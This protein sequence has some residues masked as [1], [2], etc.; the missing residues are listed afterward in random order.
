MS[1]TH[2]SGSPRH[3]GQSPVATTMRPRHGLHI[4]SGCVA[5]HG[6]AST[7]AIGGRSWQMWHTS[8][9][10]GRSAASGGAGSAL[11][12]SGGSSAKP[13]VREAGAV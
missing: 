8:E 13:R 2:G 4:F 10:S 5:M 11:L 1:R 7:A 12:S 6:N 9:F 3:H